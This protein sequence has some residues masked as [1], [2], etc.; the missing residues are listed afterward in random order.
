MISGAYYIDTKYNIRKCWKDV[1]CKLDYFGRDI[2]NE[3]EP[4][5]ECHQIVYNS[6][7]RRFNIT[8]YDNDFEVI[9]FVES[10]ICY[11]FQIQYLPLEALTHPTCEVTSDVITLSGAFD[12]LGDV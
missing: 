10:V 3:H 5:P 11:N 6:Y 9:K 1:I 7:N 2:I 12:S 4:F 8:L